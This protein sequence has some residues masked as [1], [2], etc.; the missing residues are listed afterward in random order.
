MCC[1][2]YARLCCP[3]LTTWREHPNIGDGMAVLLYLHWGVCIRRTID[4]LRGTAGETALTWP[5][6]IGVGGAQDAAHR[7][8]EGSCVA[9]GCFKATGAL[10][11][12]S[13]LTP[14]L[15]KFVFCRL[16]HGLRCVC[17]GSLLIRAPSQA[18]VR[19]VIRTGSVAVDSR[20]S[21]VLPAA[22][23]YGILNIRGRIL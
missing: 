18:A 3:I 8:R 23:H 1:I 21:G 19:R 22:F 10:R 5:R 16:T 14:R 7:D 9:F 6:T 20:R 13:R 11:S 12:V 2:G 15:H 4:L 17:V